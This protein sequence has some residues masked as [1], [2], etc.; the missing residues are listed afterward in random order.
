MAGAA[1]K[2]EERARHFR[3]IIVELCLKRQP[4]HGWMSLPEIRASVKLDPAEF[5]EK[6]END[7][8]VEKS[9]D[10]LRLRY[11]ESLDYP[12]HVDVEYPSPPPSAAAAA[13]S[14]AAIALQSPPTAPRVPGVHSVFNLV[15]KN[16]V[17]TL[18]RDLKPLSGFIELTDE[19]IQQLK[20]P[21]GG[22]LFRRTCL[23][24]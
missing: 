19:L 8:N 21:C 6:L 13:P 16:D 4:G 9:D 5:L 24:R 23:G 22:A 11:V 10:G 2:K 20:E 12:S 1:E 15:R 3:L 7:P 14:A 18:Q 17:E